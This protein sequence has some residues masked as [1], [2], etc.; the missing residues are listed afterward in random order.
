MLG[1]FPRGEAGT[2]VIGRCALHIG[3]GW[4][5]CQVEG[6]RT[7][8][9]RGRTVDPDATLETDPQTF[10]ALVAGTESLIEA[11]RRGGLTVSGDAERLELLLAPVANRARI[12]I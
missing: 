9:T 11:Q 2:D 12:E 5:S 10:R 7:E 4:F 8:I 6:D 3:R 1:G